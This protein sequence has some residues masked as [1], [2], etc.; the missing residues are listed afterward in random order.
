MNDT[1]HAIS[2]K[3]VLSKPIALLVHGWT[4]KFDSLFLRVNGKGKET[5]FKFCK[6]LM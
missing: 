6:T 1:E 4:D 2:Q 3:I 5:I